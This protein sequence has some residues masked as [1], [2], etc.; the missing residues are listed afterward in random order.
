MVDT[1]ANNQY[2]II[3]LGFFVGN[4]FAKAGVWFYLQKMLGLKIALV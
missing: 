1:L 3:L 2:S 4:Y